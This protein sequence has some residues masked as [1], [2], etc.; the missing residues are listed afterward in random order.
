MSKIPEE[1][2]QA[3]AEDVEAYGAVIVFAGNKDGVDYYTIEYPEPVEVGF[4]I[5]YGYDD[6]IVS[7]T[8]GEESLDLLDILSEN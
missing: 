7:I 5:V 3:F 8:G 1:I 2:K 6:G 4:P